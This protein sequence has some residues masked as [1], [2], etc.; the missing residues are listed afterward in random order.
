MTD[1][2]LKKEQAVGR[3]IS[4]R[5]GTVLIFYISLSLFFATLVGYL[6][7]F[8]VNRAQA[9]SREN[10]LKDVRIRQDELR[11]ELINQIFSLESKLANIQKLSGSH[12][13]TSNVLKF[14]EENTLP[15]VRFLTFDFKSDT[16]RLEMA[17]DA[18]SYATLT[19]QIILLEK[20]PQIE[21]V[22]FGGLTLGGN[23]LVNFRITIVFRPSLLLN[24]PFVEEEISG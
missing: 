2:L 1:F 23:N 18:A 19:E 14:L 16:R 13:F 22:E 17:G 12:I 20:H 24:P 7:L 4:L 11:P 6:I 9:S 8:F 15:N 21:K 10:L 3:F 5:R